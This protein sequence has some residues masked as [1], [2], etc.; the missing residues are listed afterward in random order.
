MAHA[1]QAEI[2]APV[3]RVGRY[4]FFSLVHAPQGA[5]AALNRLVPMVDGQAVV[6]GLGMDFQTVE[7]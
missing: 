6:V 5:G 1:A 2:M 4:L 7:L 3:P